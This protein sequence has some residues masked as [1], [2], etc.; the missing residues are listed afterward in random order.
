[1][2]RVTPN[3]SID[4]QA[5]EWDFVRSSGP[6]GQNVNKV[7]TAVQ[8]RFR[9]PTSGLPAEVQQRLSTLAGSRL[10]TDGTLVI[11]ARRFRSQA[12]NR[13]DAMERL[14]ELIRQSA[15]RPKRR[16]K[17]IPTLGSRER[18]LDSKRRRSQTKRQR[19]EEPQ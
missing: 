13:D 2:L 8:L 6:G 7:A 5:L 10:S 3:I 17:T 12:R 1:M 19:N 11:D 16:R 4:E 15:V 9:V 14:L 18:R